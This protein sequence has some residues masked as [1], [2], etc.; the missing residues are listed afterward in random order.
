MG[1]VGSLALGGALGTVAILIK[2]EIL[3]VVRRRRVRDRGGVGGDAGRVV[4]A[5]RQARLPDGAA[6]PSLRA[7]RLGGAE[8]HR[9]LRDRRDHLRA[10]QPDDVEAAVTQDERDSTSRSASGRS[11]ARRGAA[12]RRRSC[13]CAAERSVTLTRRQ[14]RRLRDARRLQ[15]RRRD[16]RARHR[17]IADDVRRAPISSSSSPGVPL[18]LPAI[19]AA[20][21]RGVPVIGELEL[22][23]RWLKGRVIAITGTKGKSTTTT[24]V[25]RMLQAAGRRVL[26]GGNI[27]VPLSAQVDDS[28]DDT[29]H[30]VEASSFQLETTDT[31]HP[32]IAALLNFSPDHLDRHPSEA[33]YG[34]AKARIFANQTA[35]DW[36]VVN[37]DSPAGAGAGRRRRARR[38]LRYAVEHPHDAAIFVEREFIW[39]R[40]SEGETPLV[41]L[42]AIQLAGRHMLSNVDGGQPRSA[43]PPARPAKRWR[44]RS[45]ASPASSTSWSRSRRSAACGSSTTRRRPTSTRRGRSIESFDRVVAIRRRPL[46]GRRVRGSARAA[47]GARPRRRRDRRSAAAR[48]QRARRRGA[49]RRGRLDGATRSRARGSWRGPTA[50][51]CSRRRVRASTC[52][53]TTRIAG[54]CSRRKCAVEEL[55]SRGR[56]ERDDALH[57]PSVHEP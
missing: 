39:Q 4:Q 14:D 45:R 13:W 55:T 5:D 28:T 53:W 49:A 56:D 21:R 32:W 15:R 10:L 2:Q 25:G 11:S 41:P 12:W 43:T 44:A 22:A 42:A 29:V 24:L 34:A 18:E 17:T 16:A 8:G 51:C 37:A 36:A 40:T 30:V 46:Q 48:A 3:L 26:V 33:A 7:D 52:S 6:A 57:G 35:D 50:S 1:D 20:A 19:A 54:A 27:G 47:R 38:R 9:A 31:F 23:F